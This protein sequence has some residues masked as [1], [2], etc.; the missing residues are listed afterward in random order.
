MCTKTATVL[1]KC[2]GNY[3]HDKNVDCR[4]HMFIYTVTSI[5]FF[6]GGG[7]NLYNTL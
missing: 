2:S 5:F 6:G 3:F 1:I 4:L 7:F